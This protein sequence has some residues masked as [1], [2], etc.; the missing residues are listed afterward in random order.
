MKAV[1]LFLTLCALCAWAAE[2]PKVFMMTHNSLLSKGVDGEQTL[3]AGG[4]ADT[5]EVIKLFRERCPTVAVNMRLDKADYMVLARDDGSGRGRKGRKIVVSNPDGD[6]LF[7]KSYRTF[8]SAVKDACKAITAD[9]S[10][11]SK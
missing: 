11:K 4:D 10:L 8:G 3:S 6:V 7:A 9:W 1:A 2:K 5:A